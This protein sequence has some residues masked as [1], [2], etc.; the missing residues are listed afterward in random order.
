MQRK[1]GNF[2][3]KKFITCLLTFIFVFSAVCNASSGKMELPA[4]SKETALSNSTDYILKNFS[5]IANEVDFNDGVVSYNKSE[6]YGYIVSFTR[7]INDIPYPNDSVMLFLDKDTGEVLDYSIDFTEGLTVDDGPS[8]IS[9]REAREKYIASNGLSLRYNKKITQDG[10]KIY[11]TYQ[12]DENLL[13][14]AQT[15]N[16]ITVPYEIPTDGYFDIS[17]MSEKSSGYIDSY[18]DLIT[19]SDADKIIRQ[20][21]EFQITDRYDIN[22]AEYLKCSDG[23]YLISLLYKSANDK[24]TVTLNAKSGVVVEYSDESASN[25]AG[26][27]YDQNNNISSVIDKYYSGYKQDM[28]KHIFVTDDYSVCLLE[29]DVGGIPYKGNGLYICFNNFG[30]LLKLSFLWEDEEFPST[31]GIIDSESAY[32]SFFEKC[33]LTL[34]YYKRENNRL[35]PV[36]QKSSKG[37][38]IIDAY[39]GRQLNYDGSAYYSVKSLNYLDISS[40]YAGE[41]AKKLS[42]C[43]IYVSS[44]N[45]FLDDPISQEEY[46][47]LISEVITGTKPVLNITGYITEDQ[48]EMLYKYM[49]SKQVLE[50]SETNYDGYVTRADAVK[51]FLCVLGYKTVADMEDIFVP[52]FKDNDDIPS[53]LLGYVELARSMN[54]I[55]GH[56]DNSF[57]PN[58]Y[59]TNGESLTILY[60]YLKR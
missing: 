18:S 29:R 26:S 55:S 30:K 38:G 45:V 7:T 11:L 39:T 19:T 52:H 42:D 13:I 20:I 35:T 47:L 51:Y 48:R 27:K 9:K 53:G 59:I 10:V 33:D 49:Y 16:T 25:V 32:S 60:N 36:Y 34:S 37:T 6:P 56:G 58:E 31:N 28:T 24:K 54:I 57:C 8:V 4:V 2:I 40:N 12:A 5:E 15:S 1:I 21:K 22:S 46:L 17:S 41:I 50:P 23:T 44:G 43:D 3:M 14:N